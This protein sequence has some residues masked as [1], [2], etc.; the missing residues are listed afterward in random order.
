MVD[1]FLD[2]ACECDVAVGTVNRD[3]AATEDL[4]CGRTWMR[5][6]DAQVTGANLFALRSDRV[7]PGLGFWQKIE[8]HRKKPWRMAWE[9]GPG[10]LLRL[11]LKQ[12]PFENAISEIGHRLGLE[13]RA[14]QIPYARA[15]VDVDKPSDHALVES[16]LARAPG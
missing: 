10:L 12:I 3:S 14:L 6:K 15:G 1:W 2:Q 9:I 16:L 8:S 5:F 13:A 11:L 4:D 7:L